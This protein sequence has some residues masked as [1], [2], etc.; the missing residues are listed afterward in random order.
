MPADAVATAIV[1]AVTDGGGAGITIDQVRAAAVAADPDLAVAPD[2]RSRLRACLDDLA[3][4]GTVRLPAGRTGW[5]RAGVPELPLRVRPPQRPAAPK[6]APVRLPADLRP[7]L[8]GADRLD[9]P[10]ADEVALLR[11][12]SDYLRDRPDPPI[13]VPSRIRS[14]ELFGDE[15]RLDALVGTRLFRLGILTLDLLDCYPTSPPFVWAPVGDGPEL[16]IVENHHVYALLT[17]SLRARPR[18]DIGR[19]GWGGGKGFIR[20]AAYAR[21]LESPPDRIWYFGDVDAAGLDI[22]TAAAAAGRIDVIPAAGLYTATLDATPAATVA[23]GQGDAMRLAAWMPEP[24]RAH[25]IELLVGGQRVAQEA[26]GRPV[27]DELDHWL[28]LS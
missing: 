26:V 12:V 22:P 16:L 23:I 24:L 19:L 4:A 10:R 5:D 7:E 25:V 20:S 17:D 3:A 15:K 27:A 8:A 6:P 1:A 13:R 2:E 18:L 28:A 11:R 9:R 14:F 21:E